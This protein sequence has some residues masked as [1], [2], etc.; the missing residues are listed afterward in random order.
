MSAVPGEQLDGPVGTGIGDRSV[1][2]RL[3]G[4][5]VDVRDT[6]ERPAAP[7]GDVAVRHGFDHGDGADDRPRA[8]EP[9]DY[10]VQADGSD[11]EVAVGRGIGARFAGAVVAGV[12]V[13]LLAP[14]LVAVLA[15]ITFL[16]RSKAKRTAQPQWGAPT[17]WR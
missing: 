9:G 17:G 10:R 1:G 14:V 6:G 15:L 3:P 16:R 2:D 13:I 7:H 8:D 12:A 4:H 11:G 5:R